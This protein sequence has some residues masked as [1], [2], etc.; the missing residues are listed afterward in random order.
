MDMSIFD[1]N[2]GANSAEGKG[3]HCDYFFS[4]I[5]FPSKGMGIEAGFLFDSALSMI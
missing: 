5:F 3:A 2:S 1:A 4:M